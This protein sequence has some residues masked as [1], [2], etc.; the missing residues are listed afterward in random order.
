[1]NWS[2]ENYRVKGYTRLP[3]KTERRLAHQGKAAGMAACDRVADCDG[4]EQSHP[5][6][7][8]EQGSSKVSSYAC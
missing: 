1:M 5:I 8:T 6:A 2:L 3:N 4:V 7:S